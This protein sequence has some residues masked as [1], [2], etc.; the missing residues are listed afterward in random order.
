MANNVQN[1]ADIF[2]RKLF[3]IPDYQRG[4]SWESRQLNDF[5]DDVERIMENKNHYTGLLTIRKVDVKKEDQFGR[6]RDDMWL[7]ESGYTPYY[8]VDGQQRIT[9]II[10]FIQA[11]MDRLQDDQLLAYTKK[12]TIIEKYIKKEVNTLKSYIFGYEYNDPSNLYLKSSI[13]HDEEFTYDESMTIYTSNLEYAKKF[14]EGKLKQKTHGE[15]DILFKKIVLR[16]Q[17]NLHKI[18]DELDEFIVFETTNNRGKPLSKLELLKNRLIYLTTV[19]PNYNQFDS[20]ADFATQKIQTRKKINETWK[21]VYKYLGKD[22][23]NKLDDDEFLRNHYYVYFG[24]STEWAA[25]VDKILLDD[26]FTARKAQARHIG[27]EDIQQYIMSLSRAAYQW[28][29]IK[30][31]DHVVAKLEPDLKVWLNKL[32]RQN[33]RAFSTCMLA[34]LLKNEPTAVVIRLAEAMERFHFLVFGLSKRKS[35]TGTSA[36]FSR[37]NSIY[38][39]TMNAYDLIQEIDDRINSKH[40]FDDSFDRFKEIISDLFESPSKTKHGFYGWSETEYFLYKYENWLQGSEDSK[41]AWTSVKGSIEHIMPRNY[42]GKQCW[43]ALFNGYSRK[44]R[45]RFVENIGNLLLLSGR[46]NSSQGNKC[47]SDKKKR[48]RGEDEVGYYNGSHSE[49]EVAQSSEWGPE[50]ILNRSLKMLGFMEQRWNI[51]LG[52]D[53]EK[54]ELIG[55][56]FMFTSNDTD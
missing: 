17:F 13:F 29:R 18:E 10:L 3:R 12:D 48:Y 36:F 53:K 56:G 44:E 37:A 11:I 39:G 51:N 9:T 19:I 16:L 4:Y 15:L 49:I 24:Y 14:F 8:V 45:D 38:S 25:D 31:P 7:I 23:Q 55:L 43:T 28:F 6:W 52:K 50:Q 22:N 34:V 26:V 2:E 5:Y 47:F 1:I 27:F 54:A 46:K 20:E 33:Y 41:V 30:N 32:K 35:N 40:G 42:H 21:N